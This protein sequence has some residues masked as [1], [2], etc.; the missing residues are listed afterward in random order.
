MELLDALQ[1]IAQQSASALSPAE[2][3]IGTV[4]AADPLEIS[5]DPAM[6]TLQAPVLY[7]TA[8]VVERKIPILAH[9]HQISGLGHSHSA[10]EGGTSTNLT[11]TYETS[12]AL[13]DIVCTEFGKPLPVQDGYI[14]LNRGLE[15]GDRV[16]LLQV[17]HGQK[18]IILSRVYQAEEASA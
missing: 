8:A 7:L 6:D 9:T 10:P 17:M 4:T 13:A 12:E 18:F 5:I 2:L 14:I 11:G 1:Q 16:L 3:V 15:A